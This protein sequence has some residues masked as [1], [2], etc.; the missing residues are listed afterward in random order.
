MTSWSPNA[1]FYKSK[2]WRLFAADYIANHP[3]CAVSGCPNP[4]THVDHIRAVHKGGAHFDDAN[5]QPLCL[6][7]HNSKTAIFDRPTKKSKRT[8]LTVPGCDEL[9]RP[10]DPLHPWNVEKK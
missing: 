2:Q 8:R 1:H 7:H 9:G 6:S 4:A 5:L 3:D 10:I